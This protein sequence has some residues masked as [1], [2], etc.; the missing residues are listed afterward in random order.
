MYAFKGAGKFLTTAWVL[1]ICVVELVAS[2][3]KGTGE[4]RVE[5]GV[6]QWSLSKV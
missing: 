5:R 6:D 4:A 1:L 3:L 2:C